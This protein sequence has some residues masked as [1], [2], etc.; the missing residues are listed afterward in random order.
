VSERN[1]GGDRGRWAPPAW[2]EEPTERAGQTAQA[3]PGDDGSPGASIFGPIT[4]DRYPQP[5]WPGETD[6]PGSSVFETASTP[7][8][9][10]TPRYPPRP[11]RQAHVPPPAPPTAPQ[12]PYSPGYPP[13]APQYPPEPYPEPTR[14]HPGLPGREAPPARRGRVRDD[15]PR[16][17]RS[18][19]DRDRGR[20]GGGRGGGGRGF[21]LGFGFLFGAAGLACFLLALLVL[22]WFEVAG[23]EVTLADIR[24]SFSVA[25]TDPDTLPGADSGTEAPTNPTDVVEDQARD[26]GAQIA[27]SA[28]DSGRARYLEI[29]TDTLWMVIAVAVSLAVLL[30]TILSPRSTALSLL[31]G[32]RRLS[33]LVTILAGIVHGAALW[34]VFNGTDAPDPA[35]GVWLGL[36]GLGAVFLGC[37]IG[38]KR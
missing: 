4:N 26:V 17:D 32:F 22:P 6:G 15:P 36:G 30:S 14:P 18:Y 25:A 1:P 3:D 21:P 28:I 37:V 16:P 13:T 31:L 5:H 35:F 12:S 7:T 8:A 2:P 24:E 27:A 9:P 34:V 10:S 23:R 38:P 20:G 11:D 19:D 33:G 29:Y